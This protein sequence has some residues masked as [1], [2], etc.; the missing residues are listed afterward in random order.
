M[1]SVF[2]AAGGAIGMLELARAWHERCLADP[3]MSHPFSHPDQ[4]PQHLERLAAY[5]GEALGGPSVYTDGMGDETHVLVTHAGNGEHREMDRRAVACFDAALID[6][7]ITDEPL[8][9]VLHD[10]FEWSTDR[11]GEHPDSPDSVPQ[12]LTIPKWSWEG[13]VES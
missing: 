11:M 3:I 9:T 4:H 13:L 12:G 10:Y 2:E 5:W 7:G 1:V 6:V 8:R